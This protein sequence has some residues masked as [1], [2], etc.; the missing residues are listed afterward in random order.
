MNFSVEGE[1]PEGGITVNLEG[2]AP[3]I[4]EEF[5]ASQTR[6]NDNLEPLYRFD[7]GLVE[8]N[9]VGG[10]LELFSLEDGDPSEDASNEAVAGDGF[11]SDFFFTIT[12]PTASITFPVFD[13]LIEEADETF[14]YTLVG[15]EGYE[16]DDDANSG[17]FTVADGVPGGVGPTVGVTAEPTTL[18]ESEQTAIEVTFTT[19]EAIPEEGL[20]VDLEGDILFCDRRI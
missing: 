8:N 11:L 6:F 14:T 2:D 1:I 20:V 3:R 17:T 7:R 4:M 5:V 16:V 18:I 9:V 13:D 12:E 15:G 10:E 19:D